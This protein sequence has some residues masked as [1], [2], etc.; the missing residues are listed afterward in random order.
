MTETYRIRGILEEPSSTPATLDGIVISNRR[1]IS[2]GT[3][4]DAGIEEITALPDD[5]VRVEMANGF[6]QYIRVDDLLRERGRQ[7]R[8]RDGVEGW[9]IQTLPRIPGSYAGDRGLFSIGIKVLEFFGVDLKG[10]TAGMLGEK[11]EKKLLDRE[12]GLYRLGFADALQLSPTKSADRPDDGAP[13]LVFLHG[14]ASSFQGS[15]GKLWDPRESAG[16]RDARQKLQSLYGANVYAWEHRSLTESPI[17]NAL[18]L[19]ELL[20]ADSRIDLVSHSR[21]GL[22]GELLC[23]GQRETDNDPL[24]S[25]FLDDLFAADRTL[26]L[27]LDPLAQAAEKERDDAYRADRQRL[28]QLRQLLGKKNITI[29]RF[30]RVACPA[31]GTT[32]ASGRL[33]RWLSILNHLSG[34]S[35]VGD[36][37]GF[38]LG[39]VKE[40]TDPRTLP[41]LEAM[42]P[43]SALTSMLQHPDLVTRADLTVIAGDL[44]G[45]SLWGKFKLLVTDWFYSSQHD[46]VVNTGSMFGGIQRPPGLARF[47]QDQGDKV[48]HF[49]YFV[50]PESVAWLVYGLTRADGEQA[51]FLSITEAAHAQPAR[52]GVAALGEDI[53]GS[54][55]PAEPEWVAAVARSRE[56]PGAR[57]LAVVLPGIMGSELTAGGSRVWLSYLALL[58]GGLKDLRMGAREVAV[59]GLL[60]DFYGPL[61]EALARQHRVEIFPYDWRLSVRDAA[62]KLADQLEKWLP[63][64]EHSGQ[65]VYLLAHSMGGLVVRAMIADKQRGAAIWQRITALPNSKLLMLGTPNL[66]CFEAVRWLTANNPTQKKLALLDF[67]QDTNDITNLVRNYPGLLELLPFD[68]ESLKFARIELW[69]N[70]KS[71]L[72][73][74]W[75][76]ATDAS[77]RQAESTWRL[78]KASNPD[79]AHMIY[80]AGCQD[81]TVSDYWIQ[82]RAEGS[83]SKLEFSGVRQGDGTVTWK[84]GF[85]PGVPVW[86]VEDTAHD[87]LCSKRRAIPA[88]IELLK[89]GTTTRLTDKPPYRKRAGDSSPE[90]FPIPRT[91]PADDIP[92]AGSMNDFG[93]GITRPFVADSERALPTIEVGIRHADLAYARHPVLVGHY[94][95]DLIISAEQALNRQLDG[96]L[97]QRLRLG[98]YPGRSG[99]HALFFNQKPGGFPAGAAVVGL[100]QA[101]ELSPGV[102]ESGLRGA[103]TEY[104]LQVARWPDSRFGKPGVTRAA[105]L[106]CLLVGTG[107]GGIQVHES[108]EVIL[109]AAV[110]VN[111]KLLETEFNE[112]VLIEKIEFLELYEDVALQAADALQQ[113]VE[114]GRLWG[115]VR[116]PRQV[117]ERGPGAHTRVMAEEAP[118]WWHRLEIIQE[119]QGLRFHTSTNRARIE[120]VHATGQLQMADRF[121]SRASQSPSSNSE[122][123]KTLF[124]MLLPNRLKQIAPQLPDRILLLDE[125]S[126][127]YPWELLEDRW[128][129]NGEPIAVSAGMVR[130]L[131]A[132]R[133]RENPASATDSTAFVVGNPALNGWEAF[134]D[135]PGARQEAQKVSQL[136]AGHGYTVTESI[137]QPADHILDGL[138]KNAWRILHLAGHGEHN[139]PLQDLS[140]PSADGNVSAAE[141]RVSGMVIGDNAF[142][143]PGDVEQMRWV[144]EVVF[145]N[146]CHLGKTTSAARSQYNKLAANLGVQF[147]N[148]GV[149]AVIAAGWAVNDAAA[150][151]FAETFYNQLLRGEQFGDAVREAR[152]ATWVRFRGFNTWGAY[153]CYG[154]PGYRLRNVKSGASE[155]RKYVYHAPVQLVIELTNLLEQF[156]VGRNKRSRGEPTNQQAL[157]REIELRLS[158]IP[159]QQQQVWLA[160]ADVAAALGF[161]WGELG[162]WDRAIAQLETALQASTGDC[163][164]R[165]AEQC[166]HFRARRAADQWRALQDSQQRGGKAVRLPKAQLES[167]RKELVL[168]IEHSLEELECLARLASTEERLNL[169]GST[170]KRLARIAGSARE[171]KKRLEAMAEHYHQAFEMAGRSSHYPFCNWALAKL[172]VNSMGAKKDHSW[173]DGLRDECQRMIDLSRQRNSD[174]PNFRDGAAAAD[175]HLLLLLL[176]MV[177][178]AAARSDEVLL[179]DRAAAIAEQY[180]AVC[181]RGASEREFASVKEHIDVVIELGQFGPQSTAGKVVKALREALEWGEA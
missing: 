25:E 93:F 181:Q 3:S 107:P 56:A 78:L 130:Q 64:A 58:K 137:D 43:G 154:D 80:V 174:N 20:P 151:L 142:L 59:A 169:L 69:K 99:T 38:L 39:V 127:R 111:E 166:A 12:P 131:K 77:L 164:V 51:G 14:T 161:A 87:E 19:L 112:Q 121:I 103:M 123:A 155:A 158:G 175:C 45:G 129:Q 94:M 66:G 49:S 53:V 119:S 145:I 117:V 89:T 101:G 29:G 162:F 23:L 41:G 105:N 170:H 21:G 84:S 106:S 5:V 40:R 102:L 153:Q 30:V 22:V 85:L 122:V 115:A 2:P 83:A 135:L 37:I 178:A 126:A 173:Q 74:R 134:P 114:D 160:R 28:Q 172:L 165:A 33:D 88:Y 16:G 167:R 76:A 177:P 97:E 55:L 24:R 6:E 13:V 47:R 132:P 149:K 128:S 65:P 176:D 90:V 7:T 141:R 17:K 152:H 95:G 35:L 159:A 140:F 118:G 68:D 179:H 143:T 150:T 62:R 98:I 82:P 109:R 73:G 8:S 60:D 136:L 139:F 100:G 116:W 36:G 46:L 26:D 34:S 108:I 81:V 91:P 9:E 92:G 147:I 120:V 133:F 110:A 157:A 48:N 148:M 171:R 63:L 156:R 96:V 61:L 124:E 32:L 86:Y 72:A 75:L 4:R 42:M 52:S 10:K 168:E 44:E 163:P 11:L 50:N 18:E 71:E 144:P 67:T 104:A 15:F 146:C 31:R 57:P 1:C 138:H 79:P 27:D 180:H 125:V 54:P 70:L 113:L